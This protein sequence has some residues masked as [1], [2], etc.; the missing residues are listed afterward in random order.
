MRRA[1][2]FRPLTEAAANDNLI[3]ERLI[4]NLIL[5]SVLGTSVQ[6]TP[7]TKLRLTGHDIKRLVASGLPDSVVLNAIEI[8]ETEF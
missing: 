5:A 6:Y 8:S 4:L 1:F 7:D 2:S 3:E